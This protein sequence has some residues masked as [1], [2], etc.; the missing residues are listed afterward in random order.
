MSKE[1]K[2]ALSEVEGLIP[3]LRFPEFK[4]EGEWEENELNHFCFNIS[5][6]KDKIS[7]EGEF[8][9]YGSTGIIGK[10]D[11]I[12]YSGDY[13]LVARVGANAGF[14]NR[15]KGKFGVTDNTLVLDLKNVDK[16]D[17][18]HFSLDKIGLNKLV[19][20]SGQP[21]I[22]GGQL[23]SLQLVSPKSGKEQQKI[24]TCLSSLDEV[25]AAHSQKLEALKDH[26]KGLMQNLFPQEGQKVPKYRFK[27]F[28]NDGAWIQTTVEDNCLVKGR[29]GYR[30]YTTE[31]L[32]GQGEG[33]IVLGGKHIQNQLI[34]LKDPTYLSWEK[35]YESPEIMVEVG[36]IIF[37]QRGTLGDCAIIDRE[38]GPATINP[39]MVLLKN[40]TC[41]ARFLYYILIGD[42]IQVEVRKNMAM[43]AIPMLSQKQIKEF[44]FLI[45]MNPKEQQKIASCLS[46]LDALITSQAEKIEQLKLHKKGLM[47]GLFPKNV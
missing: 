16:I 12:S 23:K 30:G 11:N 42:R 32:V 2:L 15:A 44:P 46:S 24:A 40:I 10:T 27:E 35:Y 14:L 21:L 47:Q 37:S 33:A 25:I 19:F 4:N 20:G 26:K 29:I 9:L 41:V 38:I 18:I 5:S 1:K 13:I 17:F 28:E 36:D 3:E 43:G 7:E 31:D 6:G 34:E 22:T 39:S 8:P 45:P